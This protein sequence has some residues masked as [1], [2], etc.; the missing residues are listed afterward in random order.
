MDLP[1]DRDVLGRLI[2]NRYLIEAPCERTR[3]SSSYRA[4]HLAL[5]RMVLLRILPARSGVSRDACRRALLLAERASGLPSAH[6]GRSLDVGL[7]EGRFPFVIQEYSKGR[8]LQH[9]LDS[10]GPFEIQRLLSVGRQLAAALET[11]HAAGE[12][13]GNLRLDNIWLE[14]LAA[15]PDWLRLFGFG[16]AE[17]PEGEFDGPDSGVFRRATEAIAGLDQVSGSLVR[18]DIYGFGACLFELASGTRPSWTPGDIASILDSDLSRAPGLGP[19]AV[20]RG[21]ARVLE[22]C[23]FLVPDTNYQSMREI[24]ADL[25]HL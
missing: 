4:Y 18:T 3:A 15:K 6:I 21:L 1:D 20:L 9:A 5:D 14:S 10:N 8:S 23:L 25:G 2:A 16:L 13:H 7:V 11:A 22:R 17:L 24:S 19:R 12:R